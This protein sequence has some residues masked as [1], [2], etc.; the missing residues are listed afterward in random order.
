M[1]A[2]NVR[3]R[4]SPEEGHDGNA[5]LQTGLE[6]FFRWPVEDEIDTEGAIRELPD[7]ADHLPDGRNISPGD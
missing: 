3:G 5:F 4:I 2:G 1:D 7:L 6:P